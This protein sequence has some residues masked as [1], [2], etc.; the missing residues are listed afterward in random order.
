MSTRRYYTE[1]DILA[2]IDRCH[3]RQKELHALADEQ[4]REANAL[5][6]NSEAYKYKMKEAR[7]TRASAGSGR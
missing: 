7:R 6:L 1:T 3:A 2:D 5:P 4:E